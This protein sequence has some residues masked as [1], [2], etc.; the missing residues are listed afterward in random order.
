MNISQILT[1][2]NPVSIRINSLYIR[3]YSTIRNH[4]KI[5]QSNS[6]Y[7]IP[8]NEKQKISINDSASILIKVGP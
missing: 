8:S 4:I 5:Q 3:E 6:P 1:T 2:N 7:K